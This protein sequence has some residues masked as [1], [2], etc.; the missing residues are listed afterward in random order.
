MSSTTAPTPRHLDCIQITGIAAH[1]YHGVE[2]FEK[3][4]GQAFSIDL[5]CWLDTR[6]AGASD[7]LRHTINY[8]EISRQAYNFL[9]GRSVDL[10]ET[11]AHRIALELLEIHTLMQEVEVTVHKP[12][13]PIP[14][15]FHDVAVT[16][17]RTREDL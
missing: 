2:D 14:V 10:L 1:A 9:T 5:R 15:P 7:D 12:H 8:A 16:V 6:E 13:A 17:R 4:D 11:V 3:K